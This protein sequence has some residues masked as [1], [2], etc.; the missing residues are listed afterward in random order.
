MARTLMANV[1]LPHMFARGQ[2][3]AERPCTFCNR[4]LVNV[5][6]HPLGCYDETRYA[7]YDAMM[8]ELMSFYRDE[9]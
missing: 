3:T 6:D 4:C 8:Q 2:N 7:S 5:L 9:P 1:D